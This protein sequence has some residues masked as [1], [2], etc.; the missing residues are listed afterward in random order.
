MTE[1]LNSV[2]NLARIAVVDRAP[3]AAAVAIAAMLVEA[4]NTIPILSNLRLTGTGGALVVTGT[5][6][7]IM[8][9]VTVECPADERIDVTA[10]A[11]QLKGILA[12]AKDS[13]LASVEHVVPSD[14]ALPEQCAVDMGGT[15]FRLQ[16]LPATD[17]PEY[18]YHAAPGETVGPDGGRA[19]SLQHYGHHFTL[20]ASD[21]VALLDRVAFCVSTEETRYYL[22]GIYLHH[23]ERTGMLR[24]VATDGH[25]LAGMDV[26]APDGS[27]GMPGVIVPRKTVKLLLDVVKALGKGRAAVPDVAV[28]VSPSRIRFTLGAVTVT[29]KLIDGTFPDYERVV[30]RD[31]GRVA[32]FDV[33]AFDSAVKQ[34]SLISPEKGRSVALEFTRGNCLLRVS[35]PDCGVAESRLEVHYQADD[36]DFT[37]GFNA[38]YLRMMCAEMTGSEIEMRM[39]DSR[40]PARV[41]DPAEPRWFGVL[42]PMRV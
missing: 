13:P 35:N 39:I 5:D 36:P 8:V 27:P 20:A 22:N 16:G 29:S 40:A 32:T 1:P 23:M 25:K 6:L 10:P 33:K 38:H 9:S 31:F 11:A 4:R 37:V 12:K 26:A 3:F 17:F 14:P 19:A 2:S 41:N 15:T 28:A 21:L 7:D 42:M 18:S 30:P 24:A 34:V